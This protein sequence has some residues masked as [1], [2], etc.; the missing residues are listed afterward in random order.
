[1]ELD[2]VAPYGYYR[3][4]PAHSGDAR[5]Y[6]RLMRRRGYDS[7][8]KAEFRE[9]ALGIVAGDKVLD[10]G[11]GT[12][13]FS[14]QCPG[15]YR[16]IETNPG[17]VEDAGKLNRNVKLGLV[18]DEEPNSYDIVTAFQVLEH[19]DDPKGFIG[20]CVDCLRPGGRLIL[21]VPD[22]DGFMG[23]IAN[24]IL[25]YPPHHMSWW[26]ESSLRSLI[27]GCGCETTKVWHEPLQRTHLRPALSAFLWPRSERHLTDSIL[28]FFVELAAKVLARIAA[29]RWNEVPFVRGHTLMVVATKVAPPATADSCR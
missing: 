27:M 15:S 11:C 2:R 13:N 21:S 18:Q 6:E 29:M 26:S 24:E 19:V 10:V 17:A 7:A 28:F 20:A 3:F 25:N 22:M 12:G 16:G 14:I 1:M 23:Y 8:E 5:F 4:S 9:A